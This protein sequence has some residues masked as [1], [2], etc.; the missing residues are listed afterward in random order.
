MRIIL[1][2][3]T[4]VTFTGVAGAQTPLLSEPPAS[5]SVSEQ[6]PATVQPT[7]ENPRLLRPFPAIEPDGIAETSEAVDSPLAAAVS[8]MPTDG[9]LLGE[10]CR[11]E[12]LTDLREFPRS[13]WYDTRSLFTVQN[14]LILGGAAG[15]AA[16]SAANWD[17]DVRNYTFGHARRWGGLNNVLDVAGHPI[18]HLAAT[19]TLY[20][21]SRFTHDPE[22]GE[23][24]KAMLNALLLTDASDIVLKYSFNTTRP[25]GKD[26]GFP[27]GHVAS[28]FAAAAVIEEY[29]GLAAGLGAYTF[30]GL[31]GWQRIDNRNHDLSDVL[32]GAALG[33]AIG[34]TVGQN[35]RLEKVGCTVMPYADVEQGSTGLMLEKRY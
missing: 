15:M 10:C 30:A 13:F 35:H 9:P 22:L 5:S 8:E 32:F 31:V 24:S 1:T 18:T 29:H 27:S 14:G 12:F 6:A 23:F 20:A 21:T 3:L 28:S 11:R 17:D 34:K 26:Y 33:F 7:G 2:L 16:V 4:I 25:N 19:G